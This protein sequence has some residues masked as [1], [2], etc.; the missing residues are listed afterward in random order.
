MNLSASASSALRPQ[1]ARG[2]GDVATT[3]LAADGVLVGLC[4]VVE[5][6]LATAYGVLIGLV[7]G[8]LLIR[9]DLR[10]TG[11]RGR[12]LAD[13]EDAAAVRPE[14]RRTHALW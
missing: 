3:D 12:R 10:L 9:I 6:A 8:F 11:P 5:V 14:P 1:R 4:L 13:P 7:L 2:R